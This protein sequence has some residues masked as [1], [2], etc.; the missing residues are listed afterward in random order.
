M[1][2]IVFKSDLIT[3]GTNFQHLNKVLITRISSSESSNMI[4]LVY[5]HFFNILFKE[6]G[7]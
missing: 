4:Y 3:L 2:L 1:L 7:V 6:A 5:K